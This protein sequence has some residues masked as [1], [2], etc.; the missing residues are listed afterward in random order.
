M[1]AEGNGGITFTVKE[2]LARLDGKVDAI[3]QKLDR[4]VDRDDFARIAQRVEQAADRAAV[5]ALEVRF[6]ALEK[7]IEKQ[8]AVNAALALQSKAVAEKSASNFTKGE[9]IIGVFLG[10]AALGISLYSAL[11]GAL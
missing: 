4:K 8:D 11:G 9:K 1:S 10:V 3:D 5:M 6:L 7:Q 2:M